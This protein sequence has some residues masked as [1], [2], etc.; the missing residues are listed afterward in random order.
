VRRPAA[1]V[2]GL[3]VPTAGRDEPDLQPPGSYRAAVLKIAGLRWKLGQRA[4]ACAGGADSV[5]THPNTQKRRVMTGASESTLTRTYECPE[6]DLR[7]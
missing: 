7:K 2:N 4:A 3:P 1:L 5:R 6:K